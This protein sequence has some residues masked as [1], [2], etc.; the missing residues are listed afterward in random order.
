MPKDDRPTVYSTERGGDLRKKAGG[1]KRKANLPLSPSQP[2]EKQTVYLHRESKGRGGKVVSL[3]QGLQLNE[4]DLK[5]L[6]K[7]IKQVCGS[8]GT[9]K[10]GIIEIQGEHRPRIAELLESRGYQVK[11]AGG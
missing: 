7:Q 10:N 9:I 6:A 4:K 3:V 5:A 1:K 2:P 11:I 8:G